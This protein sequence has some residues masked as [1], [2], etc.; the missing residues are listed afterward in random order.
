MGDADSGR[1][2]TWR[3]GK[4]FFAIA[5]RGLAHAADLL[6]PPVCTSCMAPL[7]VHDA[8]C[9]ACWREVAFIRPPLCD[10]M[11]VPMPFD[12]GGPMISAAAAAEP[13]Q[14]DRLRAVAR[15]EG[16]IRR[17]V[18]DLKFHDRHHGRRLIGRWLAETGRPLLADAEVIVPVPLS[19]WRLLGRRFNQSALLAGELARL[20]GL[21]HRPLALVRTRRTRPQPG[22]TRSE[23]KANVRA[24]FAVPAA[25]RAV[26]AGRRVLLVDDVVTTGATV[27]AC[28]RAL[29]SAGAVRVDV[30]A[31]ALVTDRALVPT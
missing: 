4:G 1:E 2:E 23:R 8:L 18:R 3:L 12:T 5:A 10:R 25:H 6:V 21:P 7:A 27:E 11:G 26:V 13:P 28:A 20:T 19:R 24:A 16:P 30:L 15:Y 14:Y 31:L 17:L 29:R 22:L 9:P